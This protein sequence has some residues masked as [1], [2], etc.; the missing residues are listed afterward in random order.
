MVT[1]KLVPGR[2]TLT[3]YS[4]VDEKVVGESGIVVGRADDG[5]VGE[6]VLEVAAI[7]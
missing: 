3:E 4:L 6:A 7:I 5:K 2:A 1:E